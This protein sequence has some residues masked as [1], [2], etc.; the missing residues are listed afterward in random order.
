MTT[1]GIDT[2]IRRAGAYLSHSLR[3]AV[4]PAR[5]LLSAKTALAVGL[6]WALAPHMPGV[7]DQFPFYAP[8]GALVSMYP[9]LMGSAKSGLQTLFGLAA[10]IGL[11]SIVVL[12]VGPSW[13]S[14]TLIAGFAVLLSG[15]GWFGDGKEYVP[16]AA[17]LVL[18]IGGQDADDYSVG[19]LAQ[20]T[21]GV[22]VGFVVN[23]AIAPA[24]LTSYATARLDAF[25]AHL[26]SHLHDI[27]HAVS[28]SWPPAHEAWADNA[29]SLAE[30]GRSVQA[31]LTDADRSRR[32]NPRAW[33]RRQDTRHIHDALLT[34]DRITH[35][36][37]DVS[38]VIADTIWDRPGALPLDEALPEPLSDACHA[39]ADVIALEDPGS[40]EGHRVRAEAFR[41][42]RVLLQ[43]VDDRT[44]EGRS[45][46]GPGILTAMHLRRILII[47]APAPA[48]ATE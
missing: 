15:T 40:P 23:I 3:D 45:T 42:V 41:A 28:E 48:L 21:V 10:G 2:P 30:T 34:L 32:G 22:I 6:A 27:G 13:W 35:H 38:D 4:H 7:T 43:I 17:L 26:S 33:G 31:A 25:R 5:L 14:L 16:I 1:N 37:H 44:L 36:V 12:T 9:T 20:M 47:T 11:A 29:R 8:L 39:V 24:P 46:M 19:Y 18:V